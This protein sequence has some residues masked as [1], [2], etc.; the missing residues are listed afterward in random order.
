MVHSTDAAGRGARVHWA[1]LAAVAWVLAF[2]QAG[3]AQTNEACLGCHQAEGMKVQFPRG[4]EISAT[5]DPKKFEQS[6]HGSF[7]C[8]TC[9]TEH[10]DYPHP[11]TSAN[12]ARAYHVLAQQ[13][14]ATCHADQWKR[15]DSGIHGQGVRM[16]LADVP[17]CSSCHTAHSVARPKTAAFRNNTPETCGNCHADASVMRRYGLRPVYQSYAEEFHGVTTRL[18]RLTTP[19]SSS[20]AAVCYDCHDA[21]EVMRAKDPDSPVSK[22]N[23]LSTCRNCH[24][25][26][27]RFFATAWNEHQPPSTRH[28]QLVFLVQRFY[29]VLIWG[30]VATLSIL[31]MLDLWYWAT[32]K[33]G[34]RNP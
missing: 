12:T 34:G 14:C 5:I 16:G 10:K 11:K 8:A 7:T 4:G 15:F 26:A 21:H 33:W 13:I 2:P 3:L 9:H 6:V 29:L 18:Y 20:P 22:G 19:M 31:A 28:S 25:G 23:I 17:T 32:V 30:T 24:E 27:G 1:V